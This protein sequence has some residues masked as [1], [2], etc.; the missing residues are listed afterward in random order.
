PTEQ[1]TAGPT[2]EPSA[3]PT[4]EP[5]AGPTTPTL[6]P[7]NPT[8]ANSA[9]AVV[10]SGDSKTLTTVMM[11]GGGILGVVVMV[12]LCCAYWLCVG[13]KRRDDE[14]SPLYDVEH[15]YGEWQGA[16]VLDLEHLDL[17]SDS[18]ESDDLDFGVIYRPGA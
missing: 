17:G 7:T 18:D 16:T 12:L 8:D 9:G 1:P 10:N 15:L 13:G 5:T 4:E 2:E 14:D 6:Q 3:D 11:F